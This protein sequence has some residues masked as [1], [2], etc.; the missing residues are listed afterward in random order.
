MPA[1]NLRDY[2]DNN[3]YE[4]WHKGCA[5]AIKNAQNTRVIALNT[6]GCRLGQ[7]ERIEELRLAIENTK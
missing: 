5:D 2:Y 1:L 4:T 6:H 3:G 7:N